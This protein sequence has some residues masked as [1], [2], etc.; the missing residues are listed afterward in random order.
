M[1]YRVI[2]DINQAQEMPWVLPFGGLSLIG[3]GGFLVLY[4]RFGQQTDIRK[5]VRTIVVTC[6]S[7]RLSSLLLKFPYTVGPNLLTTAR[8]GVI[9]LSS[10]VPNSLAVELRRGVADNSK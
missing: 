2:Y 7:N 10:S 3:I 4:F 5:I 6:S 1:N 9:L 8:F